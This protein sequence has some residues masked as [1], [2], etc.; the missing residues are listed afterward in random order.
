[1]YYVW[2]AC[3]GPFHGHK[4]IFPSNAICLIRIK[5]PQVPT[6][7]KSLTASRS[8]AVKSATSLENAFVVLGL[9]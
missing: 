9:A 4:P 3:A 2:T 1:M 7:A 6:V 5:W 8:H